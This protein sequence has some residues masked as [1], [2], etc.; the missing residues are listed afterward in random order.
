[1]I[2]LLSLLLG[3]ILPVAAQSHWQV[4]TV[5]EQ[6]NFPWALTFLPDGDYLIT[7]RGGYLVRLAADGELKQRIKPELPDLLAISQGGLLDIMLAD[8]FADSGRLY[9]SYSCGTVQANSVCLS[10]AILGEQ[11]LQSVTALF[12]AK[13]DRRGAAHY[14]GRMVQLPDHSIVLT[15]GDGFDYREQ[16]QNKG[17][18]LGKIVRLTPQGKA[19]ADNPFVG[20]PDTAAEIFTLGHRNVQGIFYDTETERLY[21]H[22]HGPKGG[23]ELNLLQAGKNYGWPVATFGVDYTGARISPFSEF[24]G[25][26]PPLYVWTPSIAPAGMTLYRGALFPQWQGN[27]FV[28]A[29]AGKSL[30][31][32]ELANGSVVNEEVMLKDLGHRLRDVRTGPDGALYLLTDS[33]EG[34]LLRLVPAVR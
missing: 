32:L 10:S 33:A 6:L 15:L 20:Q 25:T 2:R 31:R 28:T 30:H 1:M 11:Q 23:D 12:R 16:A 9:L 22:E 8:D 29:L 24:A 7:E 5:N 4:Q 21:S 3:M 14:G 19:P 13:P 17:S 26:E 27:I 18:H 34:R